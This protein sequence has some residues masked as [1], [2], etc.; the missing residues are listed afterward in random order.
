MLSEGT[1]LDDRRRCI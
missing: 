1:F